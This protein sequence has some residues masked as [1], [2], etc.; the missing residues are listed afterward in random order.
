MEWLEHGG[1]QFTF[2]KAEGKTEVDPEDFFFSSNIS[3]KRSFLLSKD[4]LFD[5]SFPAAAYEDLDLGHRLKQEGFILKYNKDAVGYHDHYTSLE[6]ACRRMVTV[7][8][9]GEVLARKLARPPKGACAS[10]IRKS[11][12]RLKFIVYYLIGKLYE[13]RA[14]KD[15]VFGYLMEYCYLAGARRYHKKRGMA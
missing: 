2:W 4:A 9:S 1:P 15:G 12:S 11:L 13:K 14:V 7:G 10:V 8:E 6:D 5:E 3:V